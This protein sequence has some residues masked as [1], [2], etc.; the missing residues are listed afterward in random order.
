[1]SA[2]GAAW[3][4]RAAALAAALLLVGAV[5]GCARPPER[6]RPVVLETLPH[7]P[8]AFTQGLVWDDG[9][10]FESSG[11]YGRSDLR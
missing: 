11:R 4:A 1:M 3:R 6:L 2:G 9:R 10:F 5:L 8:D 7:D